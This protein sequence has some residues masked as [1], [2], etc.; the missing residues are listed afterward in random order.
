[1]ISVPPPAANGTTSLIGLEGNEALFARASVLQGAA[2]MAS[3]AED[4]RRRL[5]S[6]V[7]VDM[8]KPTYEVITCDEPL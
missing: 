7:L 5:R 1:M 4:R 3:I 2:A 8:M 6:I